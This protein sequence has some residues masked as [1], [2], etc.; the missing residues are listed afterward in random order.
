MII[1]L[2]T[3]GPQT[4]LASIMQ[5]LQANLHWIGCFTRTQTLRDLRQLQLCDH[6]SRWICPSSPFQPA[7]AYGACGRGHRLVQFYGRCGWGRG[8][9]GG[10]LGGETDAWKAAGCLQWCRSHYVNFQSIKTFP[11]TVATLL[12]LL[13]NYCN[14]WLIYWHRCIYNIQSLG[15]YR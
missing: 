15:S 3:T 7:R 1:V 4:L 8:W 10:G 11:W 14:Y 12:L 9:Q 5:E 2:T 6:H 13:N